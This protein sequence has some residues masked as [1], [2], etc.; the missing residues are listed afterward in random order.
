[1]RLGVWIEMAQ[2]VWRGHADNI[3]MDIRETECEVEFCLNCISVGCIG[4]FCKQGYER[5]CSKNVGKFLH[6]LSTNSCLKN[7][8][9]VK[10]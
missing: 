5:P 9:V 3:N 10:S 2:E 4:G 6:W 8:S 7:D 1:M